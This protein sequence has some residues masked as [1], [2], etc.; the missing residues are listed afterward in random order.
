MACA[1]LLVDVQMKIKI[2]RKLTGLLG[3]QLTKIITT[4]AQ[5][6]PKTAVAF[7]FKGFGGFY[8]VAVAQMLLLHNTFEIGCNTNFYFLKLILKNGLFIK[9]PS[10]FRFLTENLNFL[11]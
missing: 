3:R 11:N 2:T 1:S 4:T 9:F 7:G 5:Q 10:Q 6:N 8:V